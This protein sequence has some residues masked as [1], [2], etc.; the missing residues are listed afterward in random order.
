MS[1][2]LDKGAYRKDR[3]VSLVWSDREDST[4]GGDYPHVV[5]QLWHV[6]LGRGLFRERPGQHELAFED[7][8]TALDPAV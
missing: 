7:R 4:P 3:S 6:F 5:L 2:P 1:S 8:I